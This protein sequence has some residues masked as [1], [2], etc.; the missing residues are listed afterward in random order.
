[1]SAQH[2]PGPWLI[3]GNGSVAI[4]G[5]RSHTDAHGRTETYQGEVAW[6]RHVGSEETRKA[7]AHLIAAAPDMVRALQKMRDIIRSLQP[8]MNVMARE[9]MDDIVREQIDPALSKALGQDGKGS[10]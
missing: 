9:V 1:M 10:A 4:M 3:R 6:T 7:N 2:T 8:A 5:P